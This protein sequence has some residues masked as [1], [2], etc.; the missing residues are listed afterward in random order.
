MLFFYLMYKSEKNILQTF[1]TFKQETQAKNISNY[2]TLL[3]VEIEYDK[4]LADTY[5]N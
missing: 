1:V 2:K 3:C 5:V 4:H